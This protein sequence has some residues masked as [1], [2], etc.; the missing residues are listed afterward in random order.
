MAKTKELKPIPELYSETISKYPLEQRVE[1][2]DI[3]G[4]GITNEATALV[5]TGQGAAKILDK[6][7][8]GK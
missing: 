8:N 6:V 1:L 2:W 4:N 3:L 5:G 7:K